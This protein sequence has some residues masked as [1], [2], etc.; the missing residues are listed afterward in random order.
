MLVAALALALQPVEPAQDRLAPL[1]FLSGKCWRGTFGDGPAYD[2]MCAETMPGGHLRTRHVV[3]GVDT[4]YRGETLY[5][6][7]GRAQAIRFAYYASSGGVTEGETELLPDGSL[8]FIEARYQYPDGRY[9]RVR[10]R[11]LMLEDGTFRTESAMFRD[12]AWVE[13]P[14]LDMVPIDCADWDAVLAGCD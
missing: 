3:R 14:V 6:F 4:D 9:Q 7:D 13:Q 10:G 1:R 2:V 12:G 11:T 8:R 5:H